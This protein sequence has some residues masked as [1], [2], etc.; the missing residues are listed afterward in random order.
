MLGESQL[1]VY[2][3]GENLSPRQRERLQAQVESALRALPQWCF[4]LLRAALERAGVRNFPLVIEPQPPDGDALPLSLGD[5]DGR[6]AAI[7]R[8]RLDGDAI[9]WL[10]DR[11]YIVAKAVAHMAAPPR[12]GDAPFWERWADAVEADGLRDKASAAAEAWA[13][14]SDADLLIEM[15]AAYALNPSHAHWTELPAVRGTLDGWASSDA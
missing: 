8:P 5:V 3:V 12:D 2:V 14:A 10:Q 15:F 4:D 6:P 13:G 11:R 7:L 1:N 9:D